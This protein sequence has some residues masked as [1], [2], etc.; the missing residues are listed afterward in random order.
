LSSSASSLATRG[1]T[2]AIAGVLSATPVFAQAAPAAPAPNA[3]PAKSPYTFTG[4]AAITVNV[5][6]ADKTADFEMIVGKLQEALQNSAR[7]ERAEQAAGWKVYK[8]SEPG[9]SGSVMYVFLI[10]PVVKDTDYTPSAIL[11]E[12]VHED[13]RPLY[14]A[15]SDALAS[16]TILNLSL[17]SDFSK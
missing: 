10:D 16:L 8:A 14:K 9:P 3:T 11:A 7:S 15:L 17:V 5:V 1:L 13:V 12:G 4:D 6:K 2:Y